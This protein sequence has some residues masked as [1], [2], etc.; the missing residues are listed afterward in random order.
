MRRALAGL[1]AAPLLLLAAACFAAPPEEPP[2]PLPSP[3]D[4]VPVARPG[5]PPG[6]E[7]TIP[8]VPFWRAESEFQAG[9]FEESLSHDLE[10]AY[11]YADD[12]RKGFVWMRVGEMLLAQGNH[13]AA[14]SAA[15]KAVSLSRARFFVLAAMDLEFRVFEATRM[16]PEARQIALSLLDQGYIGARPSRLQAAVA[17]ADAAEGKAVSALAAYR[18]AIAAAASPEEG[19]KL[20]AERDALI[21]G[22][23]GIPALQEAAEGEEDPAVKAR[24]FLGLGRLAARKGFSGMAAYAFER[25]A[26]AGGPKG[27]EAAELLYRLEKIIATRQK[28]VGLVPLS[29]K[30]ADIGFSVLA[31]AEVALRRGNPGNGD[32]KSPVILW[33]DTGGQPERARKGFSDY[34]ADRTVMGFLGPVTGDEGRS[35]G[36]AF[37]PKSPPVLYLGQKSVLEKPFLYPFGLMPKQEAR[38][39]L[40]HLVRSGRNDLLL[41]YPENG[42]GRGF[43]EAV[44]SVA[45]ET[46]ARIARSI[47][48]SPDTRDFTNVIRKAVGNAT[49]ERRSRAK[50][51]GKGMK[52]RPGGIVIADRWDRVF[53]IASQLRFYDIYLPLAGFS[54]W[55]DQELIRKGGDA[56]AGALFSVDYADAVPGSEGERFRSEYREAMRRT[57]SRFEAM[58]YDGA[59]F[60]REA[61]DVPAGR[62]FRTAGEAEREKIP[63]LKNFRGVTGSFRFGPSGD[64]RRKVFLLRIELGNFVPV[65]EY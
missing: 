27:L 37:G 65:P 54:G 41:L 47:S 14:L 32:R 35:V 48:Y 3:L 49:F 31:G 45:R 58:G 55:N 38:A 36:A 52:L 40:S 13:E 62:E 43:A 20:E 50:E 12:E 24:L 46:G 8:I 11:N 64:V 7:K 28:I 16:W 63:R 4:V 44:A 53:L 15:R 57:P 22:M 30:L 29:G 19:A 23:D 2:P 59:L 18:R 61:L 17:R 1:V 51:K 56:V 42:Y 34:A 39:V 9:R 26:R 33:V 5:G 60:L 6:P 10:L 25:A 21:D